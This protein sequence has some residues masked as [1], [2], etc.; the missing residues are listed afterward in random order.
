MLPS[1]LQDDAAELQRYFQVSPKLLGFGEAC[2]GF[3]FGINFWICFEFGAKIYLF[4]RLWQVMSRLSCVGRDRM[5]AEWVGSGRNLQLPRAKKEML[6]CGSTSMIPAASLWKCQIPC[7][8]L[9]HD[10]VSMSWHMLPS[11]LQDDAAERMHTG[12]STWYRKTVYDLRLWHDDDVWRE[13]RAS[14]LKNGTLC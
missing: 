12:A 6:C 9:L 2:F 14:L 11:R 8:R 3:I 13:S 10:G 7:H 1:R 5:R 4:W